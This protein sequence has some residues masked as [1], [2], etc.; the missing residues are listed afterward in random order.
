MPLKL[1]LPPSVLG[2]LRILYLSIAI[3][4]SVFIITVCSVDTE[5][6]SNSLT[7]YSGRSEKLIGPLIKLFEED[8]G[9]DVSVKYAKTSEIAATLLEEGQY[10]PASVF[11][12][13]EPGGLEAVSKL[14]S[15]LP[16]NIT[17]VVPEWASSYD[18]KWVGIT[19]R[20][21]V[22][23]YNNEALSSKDL[24]SSIIDFTD[25]KWKG[26]IGWA[27]TNASF[28]TMITAMRHVWGENETKKWL[29]GIQN[30]EPKTYPKNTPTVAAAA[31][32][33]I[34]VGFVN[35]YYLHR[36]I[37]EEGLDFTARNHHLNSGG[38]GALV[39]ISGAGIL[40]TTDNENGAKKFVEFLLSKA[41][42]QYFANE[43]MEYPL[44]EEVKP[45]PRLVDIFNLN[46]VPE[47]PMDALVDIKG[48]QSL[49]RELGILF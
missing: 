4:T 31:T 15:P 30:N 11:L 17:S 2:K 14:L 42:Q 45:H 13:Q 25:P 28:Q 23:V 46:T 26:R 39:M 22:V 41:A 44:I 21:R 38:P 29:I 10:S 9:M 48:T 24:P 7:V 32:G 27:P 20:A 40:K 3:L 8:T 12:S 19:G 6:T 35:H 5:T 47:I 16:N 37:N 43:I 34:H 18:N 33:E 1:I 49:L 36:F